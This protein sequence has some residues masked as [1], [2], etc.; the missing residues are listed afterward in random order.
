MRHNQV[1]IIK[2]FCKPE[3]KK[4]NIYIYIYIVTGVTIDDLYNTFLRVT[5]GCEK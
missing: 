1:S 5:M 3:N 4:K 2:K